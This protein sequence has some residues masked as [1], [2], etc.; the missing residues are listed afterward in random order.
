VVQT[1]ATPVLCKD[2]FIDSYQIF[3]ARKA[4]AEAILLIVKILND[5]QLRS[6]HSLTEELNMAAIVEVQTEPELNRALAIK[7]RVIL[8]NNRDLSSFE[9]DL[10]T[11]AKLTAGIPRGVYAISA[12]GIE[13]REDIES[14]SQYTNNFLIGSSLMRAPHLEEK[15]RELK[16]A[17]A[18]ITAGDS[19]CRA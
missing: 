19:S 11:T 16:G 8:I 18:K 15:L 17:S 12:S 3:E 1:V 9:I 14:L 10:G 4:G 2:F 13:N 6:L 7:P 5:E